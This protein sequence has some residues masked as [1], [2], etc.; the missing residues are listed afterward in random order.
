MQNMKMSVL[1][2]VSGV[3]LITMLSACSSAPDVEDIEPYLI[4]DNFGTCP[5]WTVHDVKKTD[6]AEIQNAY[7]LDY[8]AVLTLKKAPKDTVDEYLAHEHDPIYRPC[9]DTITTLL[10]QVINSGKKQL[11]SEYQMSGYAGFI[12]SEKG[13]RIAT[14]IQNTFTPK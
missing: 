8:S 6:G 1:K 5:L 12:K 9:T 10:Y 4:K 3:C 2:V 11:N 14:P 13:W 7:R